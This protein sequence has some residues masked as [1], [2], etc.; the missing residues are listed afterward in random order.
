VGVRAHGAVT[1]QLPVLNER[2]TFMVTLNPRGLASGVRSV[3]GFTISTAVALTLP[4]DA[5]THRFPDIA[6]GLLAVPGHCGGAVAPM[7]TKWTAGL[8][9][10]GNANDCVSSKELPVSLLAK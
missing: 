3:S 8:E 2:L 1:A 7:P 10:S 9:A 4:S 6:R 5:Y